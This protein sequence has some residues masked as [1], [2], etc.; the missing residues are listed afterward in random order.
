M[1]A[2]RNIPTQYPYL[3]L[4]CA[5]V[6]WKIL[7]FSVAILSP[8]IGYDTSTDVL[9]EHAT[10]TG[11]VHFSLDG[12]TR[13]A[14]WTQHV[15]SK[16]VRWDAVYFITSAQ[17]GYIYEQEWAFGWG[18]S[19]LIDLISRCR[20]RFQGRKQLR[21]IYL[22]LPGSLPALLPQSL[23]AVLIS[24]ASHLVSVLL[25][26]QLCV[27]IDTRT[28]YGVRSEVVA[29]L[30]VFAPAGIILSAPYG[31]S[32]F[33]ALSFAGYLSYAKSDMTSSSVDAWTTFK[34]DLYVLLSGALFGLSCMVRSNGLFNGVI[35]AVDLMRSLRPL[36]SRN[37]TSAILR[38]MASLTAAG[39]L[40]AA[41]FVYP[42]YI[43]W[44][45]YCGANVS[46]IDKRDWCEALLPSVYTFVQS[47]Y[48]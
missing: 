27:T 12:A 11:S 45:E 23:A 29:A 35:L 43:A 21:L 18:L 44:R 20:L 17:R 8:G 10:A 4:T 34:S 16:F 33:S 40:I 14:P 38:R 36:V 42:Q 15:A 32:L 22:V 46:P 39:L 41:G 1:K 13:Q 48:W 47:H 28:P 6:A 30:H 19:K 25:L 26:Y 5:F 3:T 24:N 37:T 2:A 7:L 31:E 9:F